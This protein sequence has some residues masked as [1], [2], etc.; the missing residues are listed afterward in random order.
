M[1]ESPADHQPSAFPERLAP[2]RGWLP[3][4]F[5][6]AARLRQYWRSAAVGV[7]WRLASPP[8][9][10]IGGFEPDGGSF[11]V[12]EQRLHSIGR[13]VVHNRPLP[14][15]PD[16][17]YDVIVAFEVLEH[18]EDDGDA[19]RTWYQWVKPGGFV[20][21]SVPA[22]AGRFGSCDNAVAITADMT[23]MIF[24][25]RCPR[26]VS[27][28]VLCGRTVFHWDMRLREFAIFWLGGSVREQLRSGRLQAAAS[29]NPVAG[30]VP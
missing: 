22:H 10:N 4:F 21:L 5:R 23:G 12:S 15:V 18:M 24:L 2:L 26:R 28:S 11:V 14:T 16:R 13:G 6:T 19:L 9:S 20:L 8:R 1:D 3:A 25:P 7:R 27:K 30:R 17:T 29:F